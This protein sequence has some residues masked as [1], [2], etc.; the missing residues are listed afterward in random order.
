M[1]SEKWDLTKQLFDQA[2]DLPEAARAAYVGANCSDPE[3]ARAVRELLE[4]EG[5]SKGFLGGATSRGSPPPVFRQGQRVA[6]ICGTL[7]ERRRRNDG[8]RRPI[9]VAAADD[10]DRVRLDCGSTG[11][12]EPAG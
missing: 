9:H 12:G 7:V 6:D 3:V 8:R 4:A 2:L 5:K 1:T 11:D 10:V